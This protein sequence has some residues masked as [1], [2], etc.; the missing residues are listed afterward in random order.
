MKRNMN[1]TQEAPKH[2]FTIGFVRFD[3][4]HMLHGMIHTES[5]KS[6]LSARVN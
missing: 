1:T 2:Y 3:G 4:Q 6:T 5:E